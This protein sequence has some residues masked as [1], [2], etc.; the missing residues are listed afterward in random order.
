VVIDLCNGGQAISIVFGAA[1]QGVTCG[2]TGVIG[3]REYQSE[4]RVWLEL[5]PLHAGG[6]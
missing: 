1:K 4:A 5:K 2:P 3:G 6:G